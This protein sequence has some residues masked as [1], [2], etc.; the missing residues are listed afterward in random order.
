MELGDPV[1]AVAADHGEVRHLHIAVVPRGHAADLVA[2]HAAVVHPRAEAAVDFL[3]D[4]VDARQAHPEQV[5][6]PALQRLRHH[7]VVRVGED[8]LHDFPRVVPAVAAL[9]EHHAHHLGDG[10]DGVRVV[11]VDGREVGQAVE[12]AVREQVV[13]DDVLHGGGDQKILLREPQALPFQVVVVR[14]E[15]L[16]DD[17]RHG[18]LLHRAHIVAAVE[19][20]HV[21][22]GAG[23]PPQAQAADALSAVA[24]DVHVARHGDD[25]FIALMV[26]NVE[27]VVPI[28]FNMAVEVDLHAFFRLGPKPD[29]PARQPEIRQLRLPAVHQLLPEDA[30][31]I[32]QGIPRGGVAERGEGIHEARRQAAQAA[33]AEAGVRLF[34]IQRVQLQAH[35][36]EGLAVGVLQPQ[37]VQAV[38]ERAPHEELHAQVINL[39]GALFF[40]LF[41]ILMADVFQTVP[42]GEGN[43]LVA[44]LV[45]CIFE[46]HPEHMLQIV[47]DGVLNLL[48]DVSFSHSGLLQAGCRH[49]Q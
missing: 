33:V 27:P 10:E 40:R 44:L 21:E 48:D 5:D 16:G 7:G 36:G 31:L 22:L 15:D 13:A 37:V 39:L 12:R 14:V 23:G 4:L 11:Q 49:R 1:H 28:V 38:F 17:L 8:P 35:A 43:R 32:A 9:V 3:D 24:G 6:A 30:V 41:H 42:N 34:L 20:L 2:V 26:H 47:A 29:L 46:R 18:L 45:G 19:Q 25:L